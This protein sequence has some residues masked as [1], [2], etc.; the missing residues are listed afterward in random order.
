MLRVHPFATALAGLTRRLRGDAA[1][2]AAVSAY[3][4][5]ARADAAFRLHRLLAA[6]APAVQ[7]RRAVSGSRGSHAGATRQLTRPL[8]LPAR[9][10]LRGT[11]RRRMERSVPF[12]QPRDR[13]EDRPTERE[14]PD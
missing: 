3:Q 8:E 12:H 14:G 7:A 10:P 4:R 11:R 9:P 6:R 1:S 5:Q 13:P 2:A